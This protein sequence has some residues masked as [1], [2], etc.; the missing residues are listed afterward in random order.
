[1][2]LTDDSAATTQRGARE[3]AAIGLA[4]VLLAGP[5]VLA[6]FNAGYFDEARAWA[7]LAAWVLAVLGLLVKRGGLALSRAG[8]VAVAGLALL[9]GWTLLSMTWAPIRGNAYHAGQIA[10]LYLGGL[11]A[12]LVL[13]RGRVA[14]RLVEPALVLGALVVIGDGLSERFLPGIVHLAS[15]LT[16]EG[17]LDQP[18]SY[19]NAM[20]ELAA[21]G[22]VLATRITGDGTRPVGLRAAAAAASAPLGMGLYLSF[23]RGALFAGAA[24]MLALIVLAPRREQLRGLVV[25]I[26]AAVLAAVASAP[27]R[28]MT[29][30]H[31]SLSTR[32]TQG[33]ISLVL[34][35]VIM[36]IAALVQLRLV[37][38]GGE[39]ELRLPRRAPLVVLVLVCAGL[40]LAITVGAKEASQLPSGTSAARFT[41]F[42]SDRYAYWRVA[43]QAFSAQPLR[44]VGAGGWSVWW[45]QKRHTSS[46]AV[47]AHSLELQVLAELGIVGVALLL[48]FFGGVAMA[49]RRAHARLP[50]LA[51]GPIAGLV[52]YL[53]HSPLDWDWQLPAL[54]LVGVGLAGAVLAL[55]GSAERPEPYR[56][57]EAFAELGGG[58]PAARALT[59]SNRLAG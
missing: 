4:G 52:V 55:A 50:V 40:A 59:P 11:L 29:S 32:E 57:R 2:A 47:D 53:A 43:F 51:A 30:M 3:L 39:G 44:G 1:L 10:I 26:G 46:Y 9:A 27:F 48:L 5:T 20:G 31:G 13:F 49:A 35:V 23:S 45:L 15:S 36:V 25:S 8:W 6:F 19:W 56:R 33:V 24:G 22:L 42:Q 41:T 34:L 54:T 21:I 14:A 28:G 18:L 7:G 58:E 12:S 16:A 37:A 38:R 17:R